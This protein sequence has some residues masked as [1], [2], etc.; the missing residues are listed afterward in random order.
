MLLDVA[1]FEM[2][3]RDEV[4]GV[5]DVRHNESIPGKGEGRRG[6]SVDFHVRVL[7]API[8]I[9]AIRRSCDEQDRDGAGAVVVVFAEEPGE[10]PTIVH[11][12]VHFC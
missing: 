11:W 2:P 3:L 1:I 9:E 5:L 4:R 10:C 7:S 12:F 6:W 8:I